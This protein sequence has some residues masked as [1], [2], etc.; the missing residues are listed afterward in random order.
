MQKCKPGIV[1]KHT[2]ANI[3]IG[4]RYCCNCHGCRAGG[5][6]WHTHLDVVCEKVGSPRSSHTVKVTELSGNISYY[7][8]TARSFTLP[9]ES[10]LSSHL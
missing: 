7:I 3:P 2:H 10:S 8:N 4:T 9:G 6:S 5:V 1:D